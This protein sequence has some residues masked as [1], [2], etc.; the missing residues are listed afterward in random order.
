MKFLRYSDMVCRCVP[1][2]MSSTAW[3][4]D[5]TDVVQPRWGEIGINWMDLMIFM[6]KNDKVG[7]CWMQRVCPHPDSQ[8]RNAVV[9]L[10]FSTAV[11]EKCLLGSSGYT[12]EPVCFACLAIA[13]CESALDAA[14]CAQCGCHSPLSSFTAGVTNFI[15]I[16]YLF[17][18]FL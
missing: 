9:E 1:G 13:V 16:W 6:T 2:N 11:A 17:L 4:P 7:W 10:L 8:R 3:W 15:G 18:Y 5:C 12:P 14:V